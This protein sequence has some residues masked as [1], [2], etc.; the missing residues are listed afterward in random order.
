MIAIRSLTA[1]VWAPCDACEINSLDTKK[2]LKLEMFSGLRCETRWMP[3]YRIDRRDLSLDLNFK[4]L[5]LN[6]RFKAL[7]VRLFNDDP[8]RTRKFA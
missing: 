3:V 7:K 8:I 1:P 2:L 6:F 5:I 4:T